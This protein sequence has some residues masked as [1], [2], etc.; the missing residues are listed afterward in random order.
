MGSIHLHRLKDEDVVRDIF[1]SHPDAVKL[2]NVCNLVFLLDSNYKINKYRLLLL[3]IIGVTP[4]EMT[5]SDAF[6]YLEGQHPNNVVWALEWFWGIFLRRVAL[7]EVIVT[8]RDLA[9]MNV[10]KTIFLKSTNLLSLFHIDKN[11]KAECKNLVGKKKCIRL[12]HVSLVDCPF[13]QEFD[14][15]LMKFEI[16]CSPWLMFV[17]YVKQTWL[18]PHK[19]IFVKT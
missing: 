19:E 1:W 9:L 5:F 14:G 3:N 12:C 11:V 6:A 18:I 4:I 13:E 10:V 7:P 17:D 8:D 2:S 15:C 16:V